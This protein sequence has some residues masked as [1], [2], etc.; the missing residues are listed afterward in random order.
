ME[1]L[2]HKKLD[3]MEIALLVLQCKN[4]KITITFEYSK[5][6]ARRRRGGGGGGGEIAEMP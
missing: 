3:R 4:L 5:T 6:A 2:Q 1:L